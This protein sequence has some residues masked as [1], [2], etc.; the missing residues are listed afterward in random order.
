MAFSIHAL[1]DRNELKLNAHIDYPC[2]VDVK[3]Y[4]TR[5]SINNAKCS[6]VH[7]LFTVLW[8]SAGKCWKMIV[9]ANLY[10]LEDNSELLYIRQRSG[11]N[12]PLPPKDEGV[13]S[14]IVLCDFSDSMCHLRSVW[15]N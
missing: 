12:G 2:T 3:K 1:L 7:A 15:E 14:S 11:K 5:Q 9:Q 10:F 4:V 8:F 13:R 6:H